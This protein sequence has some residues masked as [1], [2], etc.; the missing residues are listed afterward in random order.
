ML[1]SSF[2]NL[3]FDFLDG[4]GNGALDLFRLSWHVH[5][6]RVYVSRTSQL[7]LGHFASRFDGDAFLLQY[8]GQ[9]VLHRL[10]RFHGGKARR[11]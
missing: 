10:C 3:E 4:R 11:F 9:L 7:E 6:E 1:S 8:S 2:F 5:L